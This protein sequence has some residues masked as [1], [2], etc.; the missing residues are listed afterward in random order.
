MRDPGYNQ[1]DS[2]RVYVDGVSASVLEKNHNGFA[3]HVLDIVM[4]ERKGNE[5]LRSPDAVVTFGP[6]QL[7]RFS[8][9]PERM[10]LRGMKLRAEITA[11]VAG[12]WHP[13]V[14]VG[15]VVK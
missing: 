4:K 11:D 8:F 14:S 6:L 3:L 13:A 10:A 1:E 9:V 7:M 12:Y 15:S 5:I 2:K